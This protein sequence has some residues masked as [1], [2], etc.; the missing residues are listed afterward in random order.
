MKKRTKMNCDCL[1]PLVLKAVSRG[2]KIPEWQVGRVAEFIHLRDLLRELKVNCVLDVGANAGQFASELRGI[3]YRERLISFEPVQ[4][5]FAAM[6]RRFANDPKWMGYQLALGS[7]EKIAKINI[8]ARSD[9]SSFLNYARKET[10]VQ[11]QEVE[12]KRLD[13]LFLQLIRDIPSPRV[14]LKMDTQGFDMEVFKGA[15]GCLDSVVGLQSE[16]SV[17]PDYENMPH[18]LEALAFYE[19]SGFELYNMS[20]VARM[21]GKD[22]VELNCFMKRATARDSKG[23]DPKMDVYLKHLAAGT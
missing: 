10:D 18:Y 7:E 6:S 23:V 5:E 19:A 3:G 21:F 14:F 12:I 11:C 13:N 17:K 4:R 20:V 9:L 15:T 22:L 2:L 8:Q 1:K 16:L